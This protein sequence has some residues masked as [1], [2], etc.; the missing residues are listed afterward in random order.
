VIPLALPLL[1]EEAE[2]ARSTS[3]SPKSPSRI[4][5]RLKRFRRRADSER[6]SCSMDPAVGV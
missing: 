2:A 3:L 5:D 6:K 4:L 1:E